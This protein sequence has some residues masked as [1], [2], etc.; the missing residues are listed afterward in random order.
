MK[1]ISV[2]LALMLVGCAGEVRIIRPVA[3]QAGTNVKNISKSRDIVWNAAV[4]ALG[5]QF[6]IINNLDKSSG[7]INISYSG[8]PERYVDCGEFSSYV[9]NA[10]GERT[11]RFPG[12]SANQDYE[13][14]T[15]NQLYFV[16]RKM[17]VEGRMNL[18]FEEVGLNET[19]V[20]AN[21]RYVVTRHVA[22]RHVQGASTNRT[23]SVSFNSGSGASFPM[24]N[25]GQAVECVSKGTLESE[26]L[27]IIN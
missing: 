24:S 2:L 26:V 21:T 12:A 7:L 17:S 8:D 16:N 13:V 27:S 15:N 23:D 5:K 10:K 1:R 3:P 19:R 20:S 14:M 22:I 4:P 6:F 9:K 11:Y 18:I 25:D